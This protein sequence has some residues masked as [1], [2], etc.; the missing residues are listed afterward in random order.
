PLHG[1]P[2]QATHV[3]QL[4]GQI[5]QVLVIDGSHGKASLSCRAG[6][7]RFHTAIIGQVAPTRNILGANR[8]SQPA[9]V[10]SVGGD[11]RNS[12]GK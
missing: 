5:G 12:F 4:R 9:I 2:G 11:D 3:S 6:L 1:F 7:P 8:A 10:T